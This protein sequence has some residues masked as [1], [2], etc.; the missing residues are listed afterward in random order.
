MLFY[1]NIY[2]I[3]V[4]INVKFGFYSFYML[5]QLTRICSLLLTGLVAGTF[6]YGTLTVLPAFYE[7]EPFVHLTFRTTLM[8]YNAPVVMSVVLAAIMFQGIYYWQVRHIKMVRVFVGQ[9]V[10]LTIALLFLTRFFSVPLNLVIKTWN[11]SAPPHDW[12]Q[13]LD[14]WN[15]YNTIRT[16]AS[17][18]CFLSLLIADLWIFKLRGNMVNPSPNP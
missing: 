16:I 1:F 7:V 5:F 9:S 2:I 3:I 14:T 11:P 8:R 18:I 12:L 15:D 4:V 6:L 13:I 10:F 17:I